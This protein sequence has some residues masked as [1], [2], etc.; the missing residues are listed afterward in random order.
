[1]WLLCTHSHSQGLL[2]CY[3]WP[4]VYNAF[5]CACMW[6]NVCVCVWECVS[7]RQDS[8]EGE[9]IL[10]LPQE[11]SITVQECLICN[12]ILLHTHTQQNECVCD[13]SAW[14]C[15]CVLSSVCTC[16]AGVYSRVCFS[17]R[18]ADIPG[19]TSCPQGSDCNTCDEGHCTPYMARWKSVCVYVCLRVERNHVTVHMKKLQFFMTCFNVW[20]HQD[21]WLPLDQ[22]LRSH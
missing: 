19:I 17:L 2:S 1:M 14:R 10:L 16:T 6:W 8:T 7:S 20:K 4:I 21:V 9:D 18:W 15:E 13:C 5:V 12:A 11:N 3:I 22:K